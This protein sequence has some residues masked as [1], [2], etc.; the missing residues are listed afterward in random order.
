MWPTVTDTFLWFL[1]TGS[2]AACKVAVLKEV[3]SMPPSTSRASNRAQ[4]AAAKSNSAIQT[5]A[6]ALPI[7]EVAIAP[8][9][10]QCTKRTV[11]SEA[12]AAA[13]DSAAIVPLSTVTPRS[14]VQDINAFRLHFKRNPCSA[15]STS[16]HACN[17]LCSSYCR[18]C[19]W[20]LA[21]LNSH[22]IDAYDR[23]DQFICNFGWIH[24]TRPVIRPENEINSHPN[25]VLH[26]HWQEP[27]SAPPHTRTYIRK[28]LKA[29]EESAL[30]EE[31]L[32]PASVAVAEAAPPSQVH[33][34][35]SE[36]ITTLN[37]WNHV[38]LH[39]LCLCYAEHK[40]LKATNTVT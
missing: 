9:T 39:T 29:Q 32:E 3:G 17:W 10:R 23:F 36:T 24:Y 19:V 18:M 1:L 20:P 28:I 33:I 4:R 35:N 25:L 30:K 7:L 16:A 2:R 22:V 12:S 14:Q 31:I 11:K 8:P 5:Q 13:M 26:R 15:Y 6:A 38:H 40:I 34:L 27:E 37:D 21:L